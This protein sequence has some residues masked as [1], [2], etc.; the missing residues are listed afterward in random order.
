MAACKFWGLEE[1]ENE[2]VLTDEYF[3]N[4]SAYRDPI[5][6]FYSLSQ[7]YRPLNSEAQAQVFLMR[8]VE[9]KTKLHPMQK[10]SVVVS[11]GD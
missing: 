8:R 10:L 11:E 1:V 9:D 7:G 3:N 6:K 2:F 5:Q 4:L